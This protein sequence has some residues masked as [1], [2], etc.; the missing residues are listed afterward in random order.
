MKNPFFDRAHPLTK[1]I[2]ICFVVLSGMLIFTAL[3]VIFAFPVFGIS[4]AEIKSA[5]QADRPENIPFLKFFQ[6]MQSVGMFIVPALILAF[7][8]GRRISS[9]L[10]TEKSIR[11]ENI[12]ISISV[13]ILL[14]PFINYTA[15]INQKMVFP[16]F[17][18]GIEH[19]IKDAEKEAGDLTEAFLTVKSFGGL[20][21]NILIIGMLPAIGEELMFRGIILRLFSDWTKNIHIGIILSAVVFSAIHMQF[22]GFIPRFLMGIVFGYL[23]ILGKSIWYPIIAHFVNNTFAVVSYYYLHGSE[24]EKITDSPGSS[25]ELLI[26][27]FLS[28]VAATF[29][30]YIFY[31]KN[32]SENSLFNSMD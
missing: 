25:K 3:S 19:F 27:T 18:S 15:E 26:I 20:L 17:L 31:K 24:I 9:Y 11:I 21:I 22:Y 14:I 6:A 12:L 29:I 10:K 32:L 13:M 30:F 2:F 5:M 4:F 1:L 23:L 8:F 16:S 28:L 7:M